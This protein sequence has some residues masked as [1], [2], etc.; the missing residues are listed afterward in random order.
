MN[1]VFVQWLANGERGTSS[2][3]I[4]EVM[5]G[6]AVV[7][8]LLRGFSTHPHDP[9]D[10]RRCLLLL[11]LMP[12][13]EARMQEM[14]ASGPEWKALAGA[15]HTL[16]WTFLGEAPDEWRDRRCTFSAP[17]TYALMRELIGG[18]KA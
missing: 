17:K 15:W 8:P 13:W 11:D 9:A 12:E 18:A 1:P 4:A 2:E 7:N 5:T 14:A 3:R 16:K 6:M 10:L